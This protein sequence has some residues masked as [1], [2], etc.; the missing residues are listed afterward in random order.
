[1]NTTGRRVTAT[2]LLS[3]GLVVL[4]STPAPGA[5]QAARAFATPEEAVRALAEVVR[6]GDL[7]ALVSMFGPG[8]EGLVDE[9]DPATGRRNREVF[10]V[11][12][13]EGWSVSELAPDR[14]ELVLGRESWPFPVPLVKS[15]A[16]WAFDGPAGKE[17]VLARRIGRNELAAVR[18][19]RAYARAQ[20][21]YASQGRDGAPAGTYARKLRST[22]GAQDGLY[23]PS[24]R[25]E[26]RSPLGDMVASAAAEGT[27]LSTP[28]QDRAPFHGYLFRILE[29]QGPNAPGGAR[30]YVV[31]GRMSGGF[32]LIAWPAR[33]DSTGVMTFLVGPDGTVYEKDLGPET[34]GRA[35]QFER[36]DPDSGWRPFSN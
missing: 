5:G 33:Y 16:G 36:F 20:R 10:L 22:A 6:A 17:E 18:I 3:M 12:F 4:L 9:S 24:T 15:A 31:D 8:S 1:M 7:P 23:W 28:R 32:A 25:G 26:P 34:A 14:K 29:A 11:A 21:H 27:D 2:A 19:C 13:A 35:T 30:A